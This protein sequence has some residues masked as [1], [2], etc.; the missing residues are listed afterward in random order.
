MELND[1]DIVEIKNDL[2]R[3]TTQI[4]KAYQ[5]SV[6]KYTEEKKKSYVD[7]EEQN[8]VNGSLVSLVEGNEKQ[9]QELTESLKSKENENVALSSKIQSLEN[10]IAELKTEKTNSERHD[11]LKAQATEIVA[12]S[13]EIDRLNRLL[14][15]KET[16]VKMM[17]G[18]KTTDNTPDKKASDEKRATEEKEVD[19]KVEEKV[20]TSD[21][22]V[23]ASDEKVEASDEKVEEDDGEELEIIKYRKKEYYIDTSDPPNVYEILEDDEMGS[24]IGTWQEKSGKNGKM[25]YAVVKD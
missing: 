19:E 24:K 20:E 5:G 21:E 16:N 6:V 10:H 8:N 15:K 25:K 13:N 3:L 9:I 14:S 23:E 1:K 4:L 17:I 12:K 22:K 2:N 18:D 7:L 11:M